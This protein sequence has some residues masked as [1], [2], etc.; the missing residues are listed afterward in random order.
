LITEIVVMHKKNKNRLSESVNTIRIII[1]VKLYII[2]E[3]NAKPFNYW[4]VKGFLFI[5]KYMN[6]IVIMQIDDAL[7][8]TLSFNKLII[9]ININ[10]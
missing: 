6:V 7:A 5:C 4:F 2:C 10:L 1:I 8:L 9:I 3:T